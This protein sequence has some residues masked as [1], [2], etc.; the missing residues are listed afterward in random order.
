VNFLVIRS[1][2]FTII[3]DLTGAFQSNT[4]IGS[5][6]EWVYAKMYN[7]HPSYVSLKFT[8]IAYM[9]VRCKTVFLLSLERQNCE[10]FCKLVEII[11]YLGEIYSIHIFVI[12]VGI[13]T[14]DALDVLLLL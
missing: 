5:L 8:E 14:R 11:F 2:L 4:F 7:F 9:P 1:T 12:V 13:L 10:Y 6:I 3:F